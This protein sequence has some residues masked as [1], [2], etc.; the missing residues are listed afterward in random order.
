MHTLRHRFLKNAEMRMIG[1]NSSREYRK[2]CLTCNS[3]MIRVDI[4]PSDFDFFAWPGKINKI[5][6]QNDILV[7]WHSPRWD[8]TRGFLNG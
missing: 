6:K 7:A 8:R 3:G 2:P 4:D 5:C 1:F